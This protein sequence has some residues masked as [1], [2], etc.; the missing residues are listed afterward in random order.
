MPSIACLGRFAVGI[1]AV[2]TPA[3]LPPADALPALDWAD[4]ACETYLTEHK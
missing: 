2:E 4:F 3:W 1:T